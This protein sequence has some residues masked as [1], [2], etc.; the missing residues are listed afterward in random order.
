MPPPPM[1]VFNFYYHQQ[2]HLQAMSRPEI[3]GTTCSPLLKFQIRHLSH[4][5]YSTS[6]I[7]SQ[8]LYRRTAQPQIRHQLIDQDLRT[9]TRHL[10]EIRATPVSTNS[11]NRSVVQV[12]IYTLED[13]SG[14]ITLVY[15]ALV[16]RAR[17]LENV[18]EWGYRVVS[19]IS[20]GHKNSS[21]SILTGHEHQ[22]ALLQTYAQQLTTAKYC[23]E[24]DHTVI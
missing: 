4:S 18:K 6:L 24:D 9:T 8:T 3:S 12:S 19:T 20:G 7:L 22:H 23:H 2:L 17:G 5:S 15:L 13:T 10:T 11:D 16:A 21:V 14:S 1:D